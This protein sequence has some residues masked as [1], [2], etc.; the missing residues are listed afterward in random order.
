MFTPGVLG[1]DDAP[2]RLFNGSTRG[3]CL[4]G[5]VVNIGFMIIIDYRH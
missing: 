5:K 4:V 1:T 2:H 3:M